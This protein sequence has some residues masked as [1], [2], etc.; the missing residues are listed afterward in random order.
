MRNPGYLNAEMLWEHSCD[1]LFNGVD[2]GPNLSYSSFVFTPAEL[3]TNLTKISGMPGALDLSALPAGFCVPE[4]MSATLELFVRNAAA[5]GTPVITEAGF[6]SPEARFLAILNSGPVRLD[7]VNTNGFYLNAYC[8]PTRYTR[9]GLGFNITLRLNAEPYWLSGEDSVFEWTLGSAGANLFDGA[10][11]TI[12][13]DTGC[14]CDW[15]PADW[16]PTSSADPGHAFFVLH[17]Q[18]NRGATVVVSGLDPTHSYTFSWRNNLGLGR[19]EVR[20]LG[21]TIVRDYT[22]ITG[23]AG[24]TL[25]LLS[26]SA[27]DLAI[28]FADITITDNAS[29]TEVGSIVTMDAPVEELTCWS[30]G[31][32]RLVIDGESYD[33]PPGESTLFGLVIPPRTATPAAVIAEESCYGYLSW[34]Q[35]AKSCTR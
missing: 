15:V 19:M 32:C 8:K 11:A 31:S 18:P 24:L 21:G 29:G 34:R 22:N 10:E 2:F 1:V 4:R 9:F 17:A 6:M 23:T 13:P 12:T 27:R 25:R 20:T 30:S 35:G 26:N 33:I 3:R 14:T 7:F 28:G 16:D 5:W